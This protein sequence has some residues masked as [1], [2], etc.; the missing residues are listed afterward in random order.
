MLKVAIP[1]PGINLLLCYY[2]CYYELNAITQAVMQ[3]LN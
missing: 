2:E 3:T 1:G